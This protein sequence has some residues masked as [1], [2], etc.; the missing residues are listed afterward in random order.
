V[1]YQ[2][3]ASDNGKLH[4]AHQSNKAEIQQVLAKGE[5]LKKMQIGAHHTTGTSGKRAL[6]T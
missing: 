4:H 2:A 6:G 1:K 5:R 3:G